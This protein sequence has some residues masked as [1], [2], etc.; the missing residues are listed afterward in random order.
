MF[1]KVKRV[2]LICNKLFITIFSLSRATILISGKG[3]Y[4][5]LKSNDTECFILGNG[6]SLKHDLEG[7]I[8]S[9][10]TKK[11]FVLNDFVKSSYFEILKPSFYVFADPV[12]WDNNTF[13]DFHMNALS[14]L[15]I[16][17]KKTNWPLTILIPNS[18]FKTNKFQQIFAN[19]NNV[20]IL[21][22]NLNFMNGFEKILFLSFK[23]NI[24]HPAINNVFGSAIFLA[25]NMNFK[26]INILGSDHSW[27]QE[28]IVSDKNEVCHKDAHFFIE[29]EG[30]NYYPFRHVYGEPYKMHQI[31]KDYARMFEGYHLLNRYASYRH[32]QIY[33]YCQASYIDAFDRKPF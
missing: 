29:G 31:L 24:G 25:I 23:Y 4:K 28:I 20:K 32:V 1:K 22:F 7:K 5:H 2:F 15:E 13:N 3:S 19:N 8:E 16:I 11:I 21:Q 9:F 27:L 30:V 33:N 14:T 17:N 26:K 10:K 18:A 6:P 12:Y